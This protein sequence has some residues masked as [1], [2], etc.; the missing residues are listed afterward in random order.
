MDSISLMRSQA[1]CWLS[2]PP[3]RLTW[4]R[5]TR[6]ASVTCGGAHEEHPIR[7]SLPTMINGVRLNSTSGP[8]ACWL[9]HPSTM[10]W[11]R[12]WLCRLTSQWI[13]RAPGVRMSASVNTQIG[14]VNTQIGVREHGGY[15]PGRGLG[16]LSVHD[17]PRFAPGVRAVHRRGVRRAGSCRAVAAAVLTRS[18]GV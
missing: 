5:R 8:A 3:E 6:Q 2:P 17:P 4:S 1:S 10:Y 14:S 7:Q 16:D 18:S 15:A 11:E 13:R 9:C 12:M